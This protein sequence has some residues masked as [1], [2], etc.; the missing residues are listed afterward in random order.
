M[1][2]ETVKRETTSSRQEMVMAGAVKVTCPHCKAKHGGLH[3]KVCP[4]CYS[5]GKR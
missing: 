2:M 5:K 4:D 3:G 1:T